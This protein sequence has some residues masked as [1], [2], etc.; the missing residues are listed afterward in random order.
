MNSQSPDPATADHD[1]LDSRYGRTAGHRRRQKAIAWVAGALIA[2]VFVAWVV[3]VAFDGTSATVE[4]RDVGH[5]VVDDRTVRV[6][7]E[8]SM[9][10]GTAAQCAVEAQNDTHAIVGWKIVDIDASERFTRAFSTT[11]ITTETAVTGL[12]YQCWLV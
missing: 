8:V 5:L 9:P 2:A 1:D 3:W 6:D 7:Y 10:P 11:V 4:A 12:I